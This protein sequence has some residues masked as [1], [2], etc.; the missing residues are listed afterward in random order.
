MELEQSALPLVKETTDETLRRFH[1]GESFESL[2]SIYAKEA[3]RR[4][5]LQPFLDEWKGQYS[6]ETYP[7]LLP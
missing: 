4:K 2:I 6:I 3:K 7:Q 5:A 1:E